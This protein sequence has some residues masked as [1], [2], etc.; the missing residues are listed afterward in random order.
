ML[1]EEVVVVV[2]M[3]L[4]VEK[5]GEIEERAWFVAVAAA[6]PLAGCSLARF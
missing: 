3:V 1:E 4:V 6:L 5:E 2:V